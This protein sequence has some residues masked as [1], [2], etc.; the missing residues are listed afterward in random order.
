MRQAWLSVFCVLLGPLLPAQEQPQL[1][2]EGQVDGLSLLRVRGNRIDVDDQKGLPVQRQRFRFFERLPEARQN[3]RLEVVEGR[4][5][6][7]ILEQPRPENNYTLTVMIDDHQ[8]GSSFYSLALFWQSGRGFFSWPEPARSSSE[9]DFLTWS[10]RVDG[11]A[12]VSCRGN[13]CQ[14][15][16]TRGGPVSRDRFRFSRPLPGRRVL[17]SLEEARGRGEIRLVEQPR[18]ENDYTARVL[19][20]D[21]EGGPGD[22]SFSLVWSRPSR[23]E[24]LIA[25]RALVWSG[26]VD[27]HIRVIVEGGRASSEVISGAPAGGEAA[28]FSRPLPARNNPEATVRKLRGRGRVEIVEYPSSRNGYRLV[29]EINDPGGGADNYGVEVAW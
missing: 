17:V 24:A 3:V 18:E 23:D 27:G 26:R 14:A 10:G 12:V 21:P 1:V 15:E 4:G 5:R 22:Y 28:T 16:A 6:V 8:G 9:N 20:R 7:R 13:S 29:F 19:I 11:E 25:R 2:W